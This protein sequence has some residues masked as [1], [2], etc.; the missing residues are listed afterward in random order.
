MFKEGPK[1]MSN[2]VSNYLYAGASTGVAGGLKTAASPDAGS[3]HAAPPPAT[4]LTDAK[5]VWDAYAQV[6]YIHEILKGRQG[7]ITGPVRF[8]IAPGSQLKVEVTEDKFVKNILH[9]VPDPDTGFL[10]CDDKY[11]TF[12][13]C[14]VLRVSTTI[15]C[16]NQKA[17]T[18][19]YVGHVRSEAENVDPATS[20]FEHP[21][22][23]A[24]QWGGCVLVQDDAYN[25]QSAT[26]CI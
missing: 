4:I 9:T 1:W 5:T 19:F 7:T 11:Y 24:C 6:L 8:D 14:A 23:Q 3:P 21:L 18:S 10:I 16:Q 2:F 15:D 20:I 12:F 22:W 13:Y 26:E 25:P 17:S